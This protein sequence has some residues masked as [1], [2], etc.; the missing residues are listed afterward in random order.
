MPSTARMAKVKPNDVVDDHALLARKILQ[1]LY[2]IEFLGAKHWADP[3]GIAD[4]V[5]AELITQASNYLDRYM[6]PTAQT[7]RLKPG[8]VFSIR[9]GDERYILLESMAGFGKVVEMF[10]FSTK[11]TPIIPDRDYVVWGNIPT[12]EGEDD[13]GQ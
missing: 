7:R 12:Q 6:Y 2:E 8:D 3:A 9:R 5:A 11:V 10:D 13:T 4:V 1:V